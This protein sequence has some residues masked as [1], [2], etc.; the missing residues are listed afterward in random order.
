MDM[1][2]TTIK[3]IALLQLTHMEALQLLKYWQHTDGL[4]NMEIVM[5]QIGKIRFP[6]QFFCFPSPTRNQIH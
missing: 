6:G 3:Q 1:S 4:L 2:L 5:V